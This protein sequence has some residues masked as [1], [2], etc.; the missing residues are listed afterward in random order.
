M[1]SERNA[2]SGRRQLQTPVSEDVAAGTK[3]AVLPCIVPCSPW[4][5]SPSLQESIQLH[6]PTHSRR[7][8]RGTSH[9]ILVLLLLSLFSVVPDQIGITAAGCEGRKNALTLQVLA[10]K[11]EAQEFFPELCMAANGAVPRRLTV[12]S[13][14]CKQPRKTQSTCDKKNFSGSAEA[15]HVFK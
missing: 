10:Y 8:R 4:S 7:P 2:H 9:L 15:Q 1:L 3:A 5:P 12:S 6:S 13:E 11:K 14:T